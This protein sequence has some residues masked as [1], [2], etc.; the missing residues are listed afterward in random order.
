M[1]VGLLSSIFYS[2]RKKAQ[3]A[4]RQRL[5]LAVLCCAVLCRGDALSPN[6]ESRSLTLIEGHSR[7]EEEE[8][9]KEGVP[10]D[11]REHSTRVHV[12]YDM[13]SHR[14]LGDGSR[15]SHN[16]ATSSTHQPTHQQ[17]PPIHP[18]RRV[19]DPNKQQRRGHSP[20]P[21]LI[22]SYSLFCVTAVY[23]CIHKMQCFTFQIVFPAEQLV[24]GA[25]TVWMLNE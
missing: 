12:L 18:M 16:W 19:G 3:N 8:D 24:G 17:T 4:A 6:K 5:P 15:T 10:V 7:R 21:N 22:S 1:L 9:G 13:T 25:A 14:V 2:K 11:V 20:G 23:K